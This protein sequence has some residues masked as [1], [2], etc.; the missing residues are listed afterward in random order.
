MLNFLNKIFRKNEEEDF[1]IS[2]SARNQKKKIQEAQKFPLGEFID[3]RDNQTYRTVEIKNKI[4][5][6]DNFLYEIENSWFYNNDIKNKE[7]GRLY[8]LDSA[9]RACPPNWRLPTIEDIRELMFELWD[10]TTIDIETKNNGVIYNSKINNSCVI[11]KPRD[12]FIDKFCGIKNF[13]NNLNVNQLFTLI[14]NKLAS[15][16]SEI[17]NKYALQSIYSSF[18]SSSKDKISEFPANFVLSCLS[19]KSIIIIQSAASWDLKTGLSCRYVQ[20]K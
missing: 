13:D 15:Y 16:M 6:L 19:Y 14:E 20:D 3:I 8:T 1:S 7:N 10:C 11:E 4:W 12:N 9:I 5:L 17:D 2:F 18:W